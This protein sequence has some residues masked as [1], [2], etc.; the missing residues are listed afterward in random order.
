VI[1]NNETILINLENN[2]DIFN[3]L[4]NRLEKSMRVL[5]E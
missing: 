1:D 3:L 2:T 4:A 5:F